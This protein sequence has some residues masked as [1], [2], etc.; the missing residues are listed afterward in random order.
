MTTK[1]CKCGCGAIVNDNRIFVSGHNLK[2]LKK[3]EKHKRLIGEGQKRAWK[4]APQRLCFNKQPRKPVG[5]KAIDNQG[6]VLIKEKDGCAHWK[7]EH[8]LV[9]ENNIGRKLK[10]QEVVHHINGVRSDNRI[11]NL[12]LCSSM[13]EHNK[14]EATCKFVLR[15]LINEGIIAFNREEKCYERIL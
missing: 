9:V 14:I 11:E 1:K 12:F 5:S 6:Y 2:T 13:T 8:I 7:K 15:E 4:R 10:A 3:T